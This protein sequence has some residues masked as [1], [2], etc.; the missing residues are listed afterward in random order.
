MTKKFHR[1]ASEAGGN[2]VKLFR[3]IFL[4][5]AFLSNCRVLKW[6]MSIAA[7]L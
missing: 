2:K 4:N 5:N 1:H 6:Q 7:C 3:N